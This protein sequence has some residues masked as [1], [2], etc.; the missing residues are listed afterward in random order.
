MA[1]VTK[2]NGFLILQDF[3]RPPFKFLLNF[4]SN[5]FG[6]LSS[7]L[8][9]KQYYDSL[10]ASL[11]FNEVKNMLRTLRMRQVGKKAFPHSFTIVIENK[12]W[13]TL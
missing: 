9:K 3:L 11:T 8:M 10:A 4:Y 12:K 5:V 6:F 13:K 7:K 1:R 2:N